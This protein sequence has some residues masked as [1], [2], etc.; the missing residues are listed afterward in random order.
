MCS[1]KSIH[2]KQWLPLL[3]L[4]TLGLGGALGQSEE[5]GPRWVQVGISAHFNYF[6]LTQQQNTPQMTPTQV[7]LALECLEKV[8]TLLDAIWNKSFSSR[9]DYLRLSTCE[10]MACVTGQPVK[11]IAIPSTSSIYSIYPCHVHEL[12]HLFTLPTDFWHVD[13]FWVEGIAMYY[14]WPYLIREISQST[15]IYEAAVASYEGYSVHYWAQKY[16]RENSLPSIALLINGNAWFDRLDEVHSYPV[17]GS[18]VAFLLD[19][20]P[21][22]PQQF[23]QFLELAASARTQAEL[24]AAFQQVFGLSLG[25]AEVRWHRFLQ[26]W[27]EGDLR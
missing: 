23:K 12:V 2:V 25:T 1:A 11:G 19:G 3:A 24:L 10:E 15:C 27:N 9:I 20:L 16:L 21:T 14:T 13:S 22:T 8:Y 7:E 18:F 26:G 6:Q 17:A 4:L 5:L